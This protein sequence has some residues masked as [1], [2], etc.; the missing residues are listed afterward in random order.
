MLG[1]CAPGYQED[2]GPAEPTSE[3]D[4]VT[5]QLHA[6]N[7]VPP[8]EGP[9]IY[10]PVI[11]KSLS[12]GFEDGVVGSGGDDVSINMEQNGVVTAIGGGV[13]KDDFVTLVLQGRVHQADGT[14]GPTREFRTGSMPNAPLEAFCAAPT[15]YVVVG[16]EGRIDIDH[17]LTTLR[18]YTRKYNPSTR[19]LEGQVSMRKCGVLP[20]FQEEM[21]AVTWELTPDMDED[22]TIVNGVGL[23]DYHNTF[24]KIRLRMRLMK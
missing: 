2:E 1:A 20:D 5:G 3:R 10:K 8:E 13:G 7:Y 11:E 18:I 19:K 12:T 4:P 14:L 17:D 6:L 22:R 9:F 15:G 16:L 21:R 24:A 23:R